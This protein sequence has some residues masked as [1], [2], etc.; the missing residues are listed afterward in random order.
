[1]MFH[2]ASVCGITVGT[3]SRPNKKLLTGSRGAPGFPF[4]FRRPRFGRSPGRRCRS[5]RSSSRA[6]ASRTGR[7]V[8]SRPGKSVCSASRNSVSHS[9]SSGSH[10]T[11]SLRILA[12]IVPVITLLCLKFSSGVRRVVNRTRPPGGRVPRRCASRRCGVGFTPRVRDAATVPAAA[13]EVV[14]HAGRSTRTVERPVTPRSPYRPL[15]TCWR[16][17][18]PG[19]G[20]ERGTHRDLLRAAGG[21]RHE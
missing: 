19:F 11:H 4:S 6:L 14:S 7:L 12:G 13:L 18:L 9:R 16:I 17:R 2:S 21:A 10:P 3:A 8:S 15:T 20:T 1:M 5:R